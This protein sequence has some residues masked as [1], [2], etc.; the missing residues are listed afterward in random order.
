MYGAGGDWGE[1]MDNSKCV[2]TW[3]L[4]FPHIKVIMGEMKKDDKSLWGNSPFPKSWD[5]MIRVWHAKWNAIHR[6]FYAQS[7]SFTGKLQC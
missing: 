3:W 6:G 7:N 5:E 2:Y 1:G 4:I